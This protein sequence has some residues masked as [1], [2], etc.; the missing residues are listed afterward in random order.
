MADQSKL[1]TLL[2]F[3]AA[4][5]L[6]LTGCFSSS[7]SSSSDDDDNGDPVET[8][9]RE[10]DERSFFVSEDMP[11]FEAAPGAT[12][13]YGV[14]DGIQGEAGYRIEV[15]DGWDGRLLMW[16]RGFGGEGEELNFGSSLVDIAP[17]RQT[18]LEAGYAWASSTYSANFYDARAAIE[19][20]NKLA[21]NVTD[22]I[23]DDWDTQYEEPNQILIAG[24]SMGGHAAAAAVERETMETAATPVEYAGAMPLCQAEQNQFQ[25]L[26]DYP[27]VA[28][29]L[30]GFDESDYP[31][32]QENLG[33]ILSEMF[34]METVDGEQVPTWEPAGDRGQRLKDVAMHLT[35]GERPIFEE[36]FRSS[37]NQGNV[38]GSGGADGTV[39]G[40]L[41]SNIYDNTDRDY[42]DEMVNQ[43][44]GRVEADEDVNPIREDGVRWL[45]LVQ[46]DFDVPV[47]TMH[48]LGDFFV[49]FVHQRMYLEAAMEY[50]NEDMLVQR[51]IRAPGHCDFSPS[52][53]ATATS[54]FLAWVNG[55]EAAK[56]AGDEMLDAD[57][58]ADDHYGCSFTMNDEFV[59]DARA[60]LASCE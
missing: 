13:Y 42:R 37:A 26:G 6:A 12:A 22:I 40:I 20:T 43:E 17:I 39:T 49:P 15:P 24:V 31:S 28:N 35:G 3:A 47:L 2:G 53:F 14:Y 9:E 36:G 46:G 38:L 7:S 1:I 18:L 48:T 57:V 23:A 8:A 59:A 60:G 55:G 56:P 44:I 51:A 54:D 45:P 58:I 41:A 25:W 29:Y 11:A 5:S 21:A 4:G 27:R 33:L 30:A 19:D 16:T 52:E 32:F 10:H 50:G 34:V